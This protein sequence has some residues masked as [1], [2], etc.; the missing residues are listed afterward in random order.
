MKFSEAPAFLIERKP[1]PNRQPRA[2]LKTIRK[3]SKSGA[4][5]V[6]GDTGTKEMKL[7]QKVVFEN[8]EY[9]STGHPTS[10]GVRVECQIP[11]DRY[12]SRGELDPDNAWRN[13]ML[14]EGAER[15]R[16]DFEASG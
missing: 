1:I 5:R 12:K 2:P 4:L 15:L 9:S 7:R 13:L 3:K 6:N 11:L 8:R 10:V 14:W 16:R